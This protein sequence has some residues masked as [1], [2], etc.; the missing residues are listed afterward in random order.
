MYDEPFPSVFSADKAFNGAT[1]DVDRWVSQAE[2]APWLIA[3]M[4]FAQEICGV[5]VLRHDYREETQPGGTKLQKCVVICAS[6]QCRI[7]LTFTIALLRVGVQRAI[8]PIACVRVIGRERERHAES[9]RERVMT[10]PSFIYRAGAPTTDITVRVVHIRSCPHTISIWVGTEKDATQ[11]NLAFHPDNSNN[12]KTVLRVTGQASETIEHDDFDDDV[13]SRFVRFDFD[14]T[15]CTDRMVRIRSI[16]ILGHTFTTTIT[17]T[18]PTR[19]TYTADP[20]ITELEEKLAALTELLASGGTS[21][22]DV[23]VDACSFRSPHP[24]GAP[25][26]PAAY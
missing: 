3:D 26:T 18:V 15:Q 17:T 20:S 5:T 14:Q 25:A 21:A 19:T 22:E 8:V 11:R 4:F 6:P 13:I 2:T 1:R 16:E 12:W 7:L 10:L 24:L 23:Y 9:G